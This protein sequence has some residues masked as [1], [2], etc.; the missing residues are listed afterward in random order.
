MNTDHTKDTNTHK[1]GDEHGIILITLIL[2]GRCDCKRQIKNQTYQTLPQNMRNVCCKLLVIN[3]KQR[4][5][6]QP[7]QKKANTYIH[8][9]HLQI[10]QLNCMFIPSVPW[11]V[12]LWKT[13]YKIIITECES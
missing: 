2:L 4:L 1:K 11:D 10:I 8:H 6:R 5:M 12:C 3:C 13:L 7:D 9:T